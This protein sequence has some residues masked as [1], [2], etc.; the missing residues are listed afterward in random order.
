[1]TSQEMADKLLK[2]F[3][4]DRKPATAEECDQ[5]TFA[6]SSAVDFFCD[7]A[8]KPDGHVQMRPY[9]PAAKELERQLCEMITSIE[10]TPIQE[11]AE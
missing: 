1:M 9:M 4:A 5:A 3:Q 11:A 10:L 8:T 6:L 7:V 2:R